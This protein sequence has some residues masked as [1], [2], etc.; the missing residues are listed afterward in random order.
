M[1]I[2]NDAHALSI[3]L[4]LALTAKTEENCLKAC[5]IAEELANRMSPDDVERVKKLTIDVY[6]E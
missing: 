6:C 5:K 1:K 3:A 4:L 2:E